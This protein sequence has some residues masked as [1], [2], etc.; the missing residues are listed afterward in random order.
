MVAKI[1]QFPG[2]ERG[3]DQGTARP[4]EGLRFDLAV[5]LINADPRLSQTISAHANDSLADLHCLI[6]RQFHWDE[7]HNYF[8]SHGSCRYEDPVLF[9][10]QDRLSA[11]CRKIYSAAEVP[12]SAVLAPD[13]APL[14]YVYNLASSWEL[15]ISL[16]D[17]VPLEQFG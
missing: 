15:R 16:V 5:E 17:A 11:R 12:L 14:F 2:S 9:R 10:S 6:A 8:F 4:V 3:R 13:T 7:S 1:I